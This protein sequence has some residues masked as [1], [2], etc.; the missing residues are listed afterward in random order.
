MARTSPTTVAILEG[1]PTVAGL[2][3]RFLDESRGFDPRSAT[4]SDVKTGADLPDLAIVD[5]DSGVDDWRERI[6]RYDQHGIPVIVCGVE[7]SRS[8]HADRPWL[9]RPFDS[10]QLIGLCREVVGDGDGRGEERIPPPITSGDEKDEKPT[11]EIPAAGA[12]E[13]AAEASGQEVST[14]RQT[15]E[16][17]L[18]ILDLENPR[19]SMIL[20]WEE[21]SQLQRAGG[22]LVESAR[23]SPFDPDETAEA[24]DAAKTEEEIN[25]R[26]LAMPEDPRP[27]A[28]ITDDRQRRS[29]AVSRFGDIS[30]G[31]EVSGIHQVATLVAEHWERFSLM[32]RPAD[33]AERLQRVFTAMSAGGIQAVID[34]IERVPRVHGFSG[35][36]ESM[37]VVDLLVTIRDREL[38]GRLEIAQP[39]RG[40]VLYLEGATLQKA[41]SLGES[42]ESTLVEI[43]REQ[44]TLDEEDYRRHRREHADLHGEPLEMQLQ[45]EGHVDF[46]KL[47]TAKRERARRLFEV[48]CEENA[49]SF[50]FIEVPEQSGQS[51]PTRGLG[52]DVDELL[53]EVLD[54]QQR[55]TAVSSNWSIRGIPEEAFPDD[56]GEESASSDG[57]S[58]ESFDDVDFDPGTDDGETG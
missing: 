33:R 31:E 52:L 47:Q 19:G 15:T 5:V 4:E 3:R 28:E 37:S 49:G 42:T 9:S 21:P 23:R 34:E 55:P 48:I 29:T 51:W 38:R 24:F 10:R 44:G 57:F 1:N 7:S 14:K 36:L 27:A 20:E 35:R 18:D 30:A 54:R 41:E 8:A 22:E 11:V 25:P 40:H 56:D 32:A 26:E 17:L 46:E 45:S 58:S 53:A 6:R 12:A 13:L 43:L 39:A 16:E 2:I 50:A